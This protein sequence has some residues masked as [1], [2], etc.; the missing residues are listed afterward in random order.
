MKNQMR[1]LDELGGDGENNGDG[2]GDVRRD[3]FKLL[4]SKLQKDIEDQ[5]KICS[6]VTT[7]SLK[8]VVTSHA[9]NDQ[10]WEIARQTVKQ[11]AMG[12]LLLS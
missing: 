12:V 11:E 5:V 4:V 6:R 1:N 10:S 8:K 9:Q 2:R 3:Y 7:L